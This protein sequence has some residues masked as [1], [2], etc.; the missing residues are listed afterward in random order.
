MR[1]LIAAAIALMTVAWNGAAVAAPDDVA[2]L[3]PG[4]AGK[5]DRIVVLKGERQLTQIYY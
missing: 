1:T 2:M 4:P 5:A 3:T